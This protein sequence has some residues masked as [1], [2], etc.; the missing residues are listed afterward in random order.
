MWQGS[1]VLGVA[2]QGWGTGMAVCKAGKAT[3]RLDGHE[4]LTH[5]TPARGLEN[6]A[7]PTL[8]PL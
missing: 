2:S 1:G 4:K 8:L 5:L 6:L 7:G 3:I